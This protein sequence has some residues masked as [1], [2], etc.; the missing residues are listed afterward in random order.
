M[1]YDF[2]ISVGVFHMFTKM[3]GLCPPRDSRDC[4]C[5][6]HTSIPGTEGHRPDSLRLVL[7]PVRERK[8]AY[9]FSEPSWSQTVLPHRASR[10]VQNTGVSRGNRWEGPEGGQEVP[11][12]GS[13]AL[14]YGALPWITK[15][16][17]QAGI[18][19][20]GH[21]EAVSAPLAPETPAPFH[22]GELPKRS[23]SGAAHE[24]G[25]G[26]SEQGER[27]RALVLETRCG[28]ELTTCATI[29]TSV[30]APFHSPE[31][32]ARPAFCIRVP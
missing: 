11:E 24:T 29:N 18:G 2:P 12:M 20:R 9:C 1:N 8:R 14:R 13:C 19:L 17:Y 26:H 10:S 27:P 30:V 31:S 16:R 22:P 6:A 21:S 23:I 4:I 32:C 5:Y 15:T 7:R 28:L 25:K 3:R